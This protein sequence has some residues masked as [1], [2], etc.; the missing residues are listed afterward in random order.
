MKQSMEQQAQEEIARTAHRW[1]ERLSQHSLTQAELEQFHAWM[2]ADESHAQAFERAQATWNRLGELRPEHYDARIRHASSAEKP[3]GVFPWTSPGPYALMRPFLAL[4]LVVMGIYLSNALWLTGGDAS[5]RSSAQR[6]VY[7]TAVGRSQTHTLMD[8]TAVTLAPHSE[9]IVEYSHVSRSV[10]IEDGIVLFD[11]VSDP[12]RPFLVRSGDLFV[13][14]TG[15]RFD[16]RRGAGITRVAVAEG[17]VDVSYPIIQGG[18]STA[19]LQKTS[20]RGGQRISARPTNGL[21]SV[22]PVR[23]EVV[24]AWVGHKLD[25]SKATLDELVDD[26]QRFSNVTLKIEDPAGLLSTQTFSAFFDGADLDGLL[27]SL[28]AILPVEVVRESPKR[29]VVRPIASNKV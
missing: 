28:P 25:Y 18:V 19:V 5:D 10:V 3:V 13:Q 24:G 17:S 12:A 27:A 26:L 16:V 14:V 4:S 11:V 15:T 1:R 7:A 20:L 2:Q 22:E 23:P 9:I 8:G 6:V 29:F 21:A